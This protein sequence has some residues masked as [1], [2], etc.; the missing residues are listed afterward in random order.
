V[1]KKKRWERVGGKGLGVGWEGCRHVEKCVVTIRFG[2]GSCSKAKHPPNMAGKKGFGRTKEIRLH[3]VRKP[4][5]PCSLIP[6]KISGGNQRLHPEQQQE[7]TVKNKIGGVAT[8]TTLVLRWK[9]KRK[10][11]GKIIPKGGETR[12]YSRGK[13]EEQPVEW[14]KARHNGQPRKK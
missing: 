12:A 13:K 1:T 6:K 3:E 4:Y 14:R 2:K 7:L 9:E 10:N 8:K 11:L 5:D